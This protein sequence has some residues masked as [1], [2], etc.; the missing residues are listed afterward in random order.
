MYDQWKDEC[1]DCEGPLFVVQV[2][3]VATG[4]EITLSTELHSDGFY[5][6]IGDDLDGSTENEL[7][8]CGHCGREYTLA[9]LELAD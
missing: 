2:T 8:R 6:D 4:E 3:L 1:P 5:F 9:D 7:V